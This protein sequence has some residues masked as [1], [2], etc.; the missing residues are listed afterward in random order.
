MEKQPR[1]GVEYSQKHSSMS[2]GRQASR[3]VSLHRRLLP[4]P[5]LIFHSVTGT[6]ECTGF[7]GPGLGAGHGWLQG[8]HG[9]IADQ[10]IS[11]EV[12]LAD[13]SNKTVTAESDPD[14]WWALRGA[15][16]NFVIVTSV[17]VKTYDI[18]HRDWARE[19][20]TF[21]G[22]KIE[23]VFQ[24][25]NDKIF[26]NGKQDEDVVVWSSMLNAKEFDSQN[27]VIIVY[28]LQEGVKAVNAK[29]S[30]ALKSL[31]P[32]RVENTPGT[33]TDLAAWTRVSMDDPPCQKLDSNNIRFPLYLESYN[34][35]A[36]RKVYDMFAAALRDKPE[37]ANSMILFENYPRQG[38]QK[39]KNKD[40]A[41]A[42]RN[43]GILAAPLINFRPGNKDV[44]GLAIVLGEALRTALHNGSNR[45]TMH[46]YVNY[47]FRDSKD[48][49]FGEESWRQEKLAAL[50][51]KYDPIGRFNFYNSVV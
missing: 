10:F 19:T 33:Y 4:P 44:D 39:V 27:P 30:A 34:I 41:F 23:A 7:L 13:G 2:Y 50:K 25:I 15:G 11:M 49:M 48:E 12:V 21:T 8:H 20:M 46:T 36:V 40:S 43:D 3:Q 9:L 17:T 18:Q 38:V 37:F 6:C 35:T 51:A 22:D 47:A 16:H 29:Y 14:L 5:L 24:A 42:F 28:L 1:L 31:G 26:R 32:V 45:K